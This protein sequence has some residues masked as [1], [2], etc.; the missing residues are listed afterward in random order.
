MVLATDRDSRLTGWRVEPRQAA[1]LPRKS[2]LAVPGL[3]FEFY[4]MPRRNARWLAFSADGQSVNLASKSA[5]ERYSANRLILTG[6]VL[7]DNCRSR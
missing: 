3:T 2:R 5:L 7:A 6:E 1:S 4:A